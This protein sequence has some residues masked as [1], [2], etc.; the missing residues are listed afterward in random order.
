[1]KKKKVVFLDRDNTINEDP[2]YL[3][4]PDKVKILPGI[5]EGLDLLQCMGYEFII[6]SNQAGIAKG[7]M[8][9]EDVLAVNKRIYELL[10]NV[11][12]KKTYF[13][14][15]RDEDN[16]D[17]R[18]PKSGLLEK[19]L[20]EI[21]IDLSDSYIIGDRYRDLIPGEKYNIPGILVP[22]KKSR[23]EDKN[24]KKA[25]NMIYEASSFQDAVAY[26]LEDLYEKKNLQKIF[27]GIKDLRFQNRLARWK[28]SKKEIIFTNGVFDILHT[29]H[30]QYLW[31]ASRMGK[32]LI[33]GINSDESVKKLKG[34]DRPV[35]TLSDRAKHL[36]GL[37]FV[38]AILPF[39]ENT[40]VEVIRYIQPDI[41]I[42]G[43]DYRKEDLPE[44]SIVKEYGGKI[45]ILPFRKGYSTT[46]IIKKIQG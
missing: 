26:I 14:P 39:S 22:N 15:H 6:L 23:S 36:A 9:E 28:L 32:V 1:M 38:D 13:C 2:G 4:D 24:S 12:I 20:E 29:G 19:A 17:C 37:G 10:N 45:Q 11:R 42:K 21:P 30:L 27:S 5:K 25:N 35:N 33:I 43:G 46:S 31:Q 40:P 18:K 41:H 16:C 34:P 7:L 8:T 3:K 44:Y